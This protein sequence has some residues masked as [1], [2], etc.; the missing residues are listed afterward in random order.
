MVMNLKNEI[1]IFSKVKNSDLS[2]F[3]NELKELKNLFGVL[4]VNKNTIE[5]LY[6][7]YLNLS[8]DETLFG[9]SIVNGKLVNRQA[10]FLV[11]FFQE[12]IDNGFSFPKRKMAIE[13]FIHLCDKNIG[14]EWLCKLLK[15]NILEECDF[16]QVGHL[17]E[18]HLPNLI[19]FIKILDAY[20]INLKCPEEKRNSYLIFN[21]LKI[22]DAEEIDEFTA[23]D[24]RF[25]VKKIL[26]QLVERL[27]SQISEAEIFDNISKILS[28][29]LIWKNHLHR[30]EVEPPEVEA[31]YNIDF[32]IIIKY[33]TEYLWWNNGFKYQK[34]NKVFTFGSQEFYFLAAGGSI[35][36]VPD[37]HPYTRRMAREFVGLQYDLDLGA[38][39]D[40]YIYLYVKS[41]GGGEVIWINGILLYKN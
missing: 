24:L 9:F 29:F 6:F 35:R 4:M 3:K 36:K 7:L 23:D 32:S 39:E 12:F 30:I 28:W 1:G 13:I 8:A 31:Y 10:G 34:K 19:A 33:V 25:F 11:Q 16:N 37:H 14:K 41:L 27:S 15:T 18:F 40:M 26:P 17:K 20:S 22:L 5:S 38:E 2:D 21:I